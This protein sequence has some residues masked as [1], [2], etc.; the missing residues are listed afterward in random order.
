MEINHIVSIGQSRINF[1][2]TD[3]PI[4]NNEGLTLYGIADSVTDFITKN[5]FEISFNFKHGYQLKKVYNY[6]NSFTALFTKLYS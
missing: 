3:I 2:Q 1:I 5:S 6:R 4:Y